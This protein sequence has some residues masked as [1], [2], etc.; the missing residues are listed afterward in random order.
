MK[1]GIRK[2]ENEKGKQIMK[3][4]LMIGAVILSLLA[5]CAV[6]PKY[7]KPIVQPPSVFRGDN[8]RAAGSNPASLADLKWFEVF[9]D[10]Q[11]HELIRTALRS[12]ERRVGKECRSRW[13]PYH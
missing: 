7:R 12:E 6:C 13:S 8:D 3:K 11:L 10:E 5:G 9:K 4:R 2:M 1:N